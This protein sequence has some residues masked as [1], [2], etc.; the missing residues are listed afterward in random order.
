MRRAPRFVLILM[1]GLILVSMTPAQAAGDDAASTFKAFQKTLKSA[2]K[3]DEVLPYYT[4]S[5]AN[6]Q[7]AFH[8]LTDL[9]YEYL[10]LKVTGQK[11][12]GTKYEVYVE[13]PSVDNDEIY[14]G[15]FTFIQDQGKWKI[16][17]T[18]LAPK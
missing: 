11:K 16:D 18:E 14:K 5:L 15:N 7:K 8:K 12:V 3:L 2:K 1:V 13:G 4:D 17:S 10:K 9:Q 6:L